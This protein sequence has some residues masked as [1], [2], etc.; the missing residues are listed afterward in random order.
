[1]RENEVS[2]L[3]SGMV[4]PEVGELHTVGLE[5]RLEPPPDVSLSLEDWGEWAWGEWAWFESDESSYASRAWSPAPTP[6]P[7]PAPNSKSV[8]I[9]LLTNE[10]AP[11]SAGHSL[12][13]LPLPWRPPPC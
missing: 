9:T 10:Y 2:S 6:T 7:T 13:S 4:G 12:S 5:D 1:M 11:M 3:G 8:S